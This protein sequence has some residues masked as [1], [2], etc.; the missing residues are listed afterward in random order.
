MHERREMTLRDRGGEPQPAPP[1]HPSLEPVEHGQAPSLGH[2][3]RGRGA[4]FRLCSLVLVHRAV[5][6]SLVQHLSDF[7]HPH[8]SLL[9]LHLHDR[10]VGPVEVERENGYLPSELLQGVADD[11]P[12]WGTSIAKTCVHLGQRASICWFWFSLIQL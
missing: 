9:M 7:L 8:A 1:G 4:S 3:G 6:R 11:S 2:A 10:L 12:R 5:T